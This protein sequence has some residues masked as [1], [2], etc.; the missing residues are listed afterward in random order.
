MLSS[1][2]T[3]LHILQTVIIDAFHREMPALFQTYDT[4]LSFTVTCRLCIGLHI[5]QRGKD[6]KGKGKREEGKREERVRKE[7]REKKRGGRERGGRGK[8]GKLNF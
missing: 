8:S 2:K 1:F 6:E 5:G 7:E 3:I 4:K